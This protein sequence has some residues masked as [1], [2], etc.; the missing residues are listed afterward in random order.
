MAS[1]QSSLSP[2]AQRPTYTDEQLDNFLG[3][4]HPQRR[5]TLNSFKQEIQHDQLKALKTLHR[6]TISFLSWT[7]VT[8]HY[9]THH[10]LSLETDVLYHKLVE[11][12]H[13]GYCMENNTFMYTVLRSL[14]YDCYITGGRISDALSGSRGVAAEGFGGWSHQLTIVTIGPHKYVVDVGI[15]AQSAIEPL[16][17]K[18]GGKAK[19]LPGVT[20]RLVRRRISPFTTRDQTMWVI[21]MYLAQ[22]QEDGGPGSEAKQQDREGDDA[23]WLNMCCFDEHEWLPQDFEIAN[24]RTSQ[25]PRSMFAYKVLATKPV[26]SEDGE[27]VVA[28]NI[29]VNDEVSRRTGSYGK[30]EILRKCKTEAERV[31]ALARWFEVKLTSEE[32]AGI[33]GRVS[34]IR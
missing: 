6:L 7:S 25:H 1:A 23:N 5:L 3:K 32:I 24:Y 29:L 27:D 9:S 20:Q 33:R 31:D 22:E 21:Q 17:L 16:P 15:G 34:E 11:R 2:H 8:L 19:G 10:T 26:L 28:L 30:K 12:R 13:G 14:G 4:L 18:E